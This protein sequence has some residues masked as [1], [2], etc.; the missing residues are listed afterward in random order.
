[1]AKIFLMHWKLLQV[2]EIKKSKIVN[3]TNYNS[4]LVY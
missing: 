4:F 2:W 1:M 3:Y